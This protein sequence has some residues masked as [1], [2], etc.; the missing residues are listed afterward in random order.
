M[1]VN[2]IEIQKYNNQKIRKKIKIIGIVISMIIVAISIASLLFYEFYKEKLTQEIFLYNPVILFFSVAFLEFVP[3]ILTSY[4][5]LIISILSGMNILNSIIIA[6]ASSLLS[7]VLAFEIGRKFGWKFTCSLAEP[8]KIIKIVN[9]WNKYGKLYTFLSAISPLPYFPL[10]YGA[11]GMKR[12]QMWLF[13]ILPRLASFI[14]VGYLASLG[15]F[16]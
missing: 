3:Q 12:K 1:E 5:P 15:K 16:I 2:E 6:I 13:G 11:L 4:F 8:K 10:I 9:F 7:S 14:F